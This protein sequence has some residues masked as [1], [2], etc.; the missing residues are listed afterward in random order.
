M[1]NVA[2][3]LKDEV[4]RLA[5]KAVRAELEKVK[6]ALSQHRKDIA[7]LRRVLGG[8]E[9]AISHLKAR[10]Q[11]GAGT[12]AVREDATPG[13]RFSVRSL[14]AQRRRLG[15]S[16]LDYGKLIGVSPLTIYNWESGKSRP[17][18]S[19]FDALVAIRGIGKREARHR[20]E[21]AE[22]AKPPRAKNGRKNRLAEAVRRR[23]DK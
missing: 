23:A 3:V 15:L 5:K 20:L 1:P 4:L 17:R 21:T 12:A 18:R 13:T 2:A 11:D 8:L 9:N 7:Q 22:P 14:K 6:R 16:A 10:L 19:Q